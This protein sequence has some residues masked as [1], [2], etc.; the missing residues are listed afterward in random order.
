M[1]QGGAGSLDLAARL[2]RLH[3]KIIDLSLGRIERLLDRLG[4]PEASLPPVVHVAGT[5]GKG[6]V[7]AFARAIAEAAGQK[8]HAYTSPHLVRFNERICVASR[9]IEDAALLALIEECEAVNGEEPITF[10]EMTTAVAY[11]AFA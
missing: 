10:F 3:P 4:N 2:N 5:N 11:L 7:I 8:V 9:Q 6:S 1:S